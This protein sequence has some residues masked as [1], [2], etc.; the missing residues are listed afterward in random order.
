MLRI[1]VIGTGAMGQHHVRIYSGMEEVE[2]V[3]I[4][5]INE[6]RVKELAATYKTTPYIDY[7]TLLKQDLDAVSIAVPTTHHTD[8]ALDVIESGT[9]L[10][11]EKI[12]GG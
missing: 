8:V 3:G 4:S 6:M 10:L 1:G 11:V 2:F 5:D 7:H 12:F 9:N